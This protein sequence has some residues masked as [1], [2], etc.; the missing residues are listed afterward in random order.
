M[1]A[2][3]K[4]V[5]EKIEQST[6]EQED[7]IEELAQKISESVKKGGI[8]HILGTGHSHMIAEEIF[9]RAGGVLFVN[10]ILEANLMLHEDPVKSTR[11][12]RLPGYAKAIL[13][14]IHFKPE[15]TFII[16]SN[17]GRN[18]VPVEAALYAKERK[19]STVAITSLAHSQS[20]DSRHE[21]GKK[22][23]EVSDYVL[24]NKGTA[25]DA[26]LD[27]KGFDGK[28]G[29]TS[30]VI[31][32][33]LVQTLVSLIIENLAEAGIEPPLMKSANL[34]SGDRQNAKLIEEYKDRIPL[35]K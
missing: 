20:V 3:V 10:P 28:Y 9:Y 25:G 23:Y 6:N 5:I 12:E 35:L 29:P 30:S 8:I 34:D 26:V 14:G 24:D 4:N 15:D 31:G 22:L 11:L 17:S 18:A 33:V 2:Y 27:L 19:V 32:I 13:D 16:I 21:S 1:H 7:Q